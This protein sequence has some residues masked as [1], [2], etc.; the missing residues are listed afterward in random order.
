MRVMTSSEII[1]TALRIYQ[2]L[3]WTFL[4]LTVMPT[5]FIVAAFAFVQQYVFPSFFVTKNAASLTTQFNEVAVAVGLAVLI[6]GPLL[7]VGVSATTAIVTQ[8]V[9]DYMLGNLPSQEGALKAARRTLVTLTRVHFWEI[10]L[11]CSGV[12]GALGLSLLSSSLDQTTSNENVTAAFVALLAV[13][14][15]IAGGLIFLGVVSRHAL[16]APIAVL[17][18]LGPRAASKRS[19]QLMKGAGTIQ[20]GYGNIFSLYIVLAF[21]SLV[22]YGGMNGLL[23]AGGYPDH[24]ASTFDNLPYGGVLLEA[25]RLIPLF[26]WVW[27]LVPIWSTTIAIVY[28]ER[29]IRLEGYDIEALAADVW[30]TDRQN[31]YEL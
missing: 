2:Q 10:C 23:A 22:M 25:L 7:I 30:R 21:L 4:K 11:S 3:G 17:E 6:G 15:F 27:A 14:G 31:R 18:G 24:F 8:L 26:L 12:V 16:A 28:Y 1:D 5:L 29:R 9:S 20:N 19:V 13:C